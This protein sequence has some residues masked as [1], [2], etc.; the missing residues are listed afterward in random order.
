MPKACLL[1]PDPPQ[2]TA[3][4]TTTT[5]SRS[6]SLAPGQGKRTRHSAEMNRARA[7]LVIVSLV[8]CLSCSFSKSDREFDRR[9]KEFQRRSPKSEA[10]VDFAAGDYRIYS[11]MGA[12]HY[13]P[14]I[15][16]AVGRRIAATHGEK[17]IEGTTDALE[18][19]SQSRFVSASTSFAAHYNQQKVA[20]VEKLPLQK[21][22]QNNP[23]R[24]TASRR[25]VECSQ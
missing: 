18:G 9:T 14:G 23:P 22:L 3:A 7:I 2:L 15:D 11:A 21:S 5:S 6:R 19:G 1:T 8:S 17:M 24:R 20:L 12:G 4:M 25:S 13:Y 16:P 10:E